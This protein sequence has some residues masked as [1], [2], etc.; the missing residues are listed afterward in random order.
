MYCTN[1]VSISIPESI[2]SIPNS[3]FEY[4]YNLNS[5]LISNEVTFI[6]ENAFKGCTSLTSV[7]FNGNESQWEMISIDNG[8]ENLTSAKK[9]YKQEFAPTA[10]EYF[11]F[12]LL[13]NGTYSIKI[14][15]SESMPSVVVIPSHH[16]G[17]SVT[18]IEEWA[19]CPGRSEKYVNNI[20]SIIIPDTITEIGMAAF[21]YCRNLT[22]ITIPIGVSELDIGVLQGCTS[23]ETL[24]LPRTITGIFDTAV[25]ACDNLTDIYFMGTEGEWLEIGIGD[26]NDPF[27]N[28]TVT[29]HYNSIYMQ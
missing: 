29:V 28:K 1:L 6:S 11:T 13:D 17:I 23:L 18:A 7:Y 19:F 24:Y 25:L 12:N 5:I 8:N 14:N 2:S 26:W 3:L 21:S 15:D 22:S 9:T 27:D 4:C 16:N 20:T 10:D